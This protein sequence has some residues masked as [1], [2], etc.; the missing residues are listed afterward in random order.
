MKRKK[1]QALLPTILFAGVIV[2]SI[3]GLILADNIRQAR[4]S[5]PGEITNQDEIPRV[6]AEEAYQA[7]LA[8]EAVIVDTRSESEY[9]SQRVAGAISLPIDQVEG[10]VGE[11]DPDTW[12]ITYCT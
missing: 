8:G 5:N 11:L 6:T 4:I 1:N 2:I 10:R 12:Y 9:Q 7:M 3:V